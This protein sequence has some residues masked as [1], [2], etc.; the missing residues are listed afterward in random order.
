LKLDFAVLSNASE[1]NGNLLY[2]TGGGWDTGWRQAFPAP[3]QGALTI[4]LLW[5]PTEVASPRRLELRF[6]SEDGAE[7]APTFTLTMA[8]VQLPPDYPKGW[9]VPVMFAIGLQ[10][11]PIPAPGHYSIEVLV[12]NQHLKSVQFRMIK[13]APQ[14]Q[15]LPG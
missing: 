12:D 5:H 11:L 6:L 9:D 13:G 15:Q 7:F 1:V 8:A 4:R 14:I 2:L 3:F 10:G